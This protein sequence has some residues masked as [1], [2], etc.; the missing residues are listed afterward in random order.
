MLTADD[1]G[2]Y[3]YEVVYDTVLL[4]GDT[5]DT[6]QDESVSILQDAGLDF[7][8]EGVYLMAELPYSYLMFSGSV[9]VVSNGDGVWDISVDITGGGFHE[10]TVTDA[11]EGAE[12]V[13]GLIVDEY[14]K[15]TDPDEY[16][17][18]DSV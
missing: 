8:Q 4:Y 16:D 12:F 13:T 3:D 9:A 15:D 2:V 7:S 6:F 5:D 14:R 1:D 10:K 17:L 11:D 18:A